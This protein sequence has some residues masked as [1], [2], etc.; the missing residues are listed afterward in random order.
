MRETYRPTRR[1]GSDFGAH[2]SQPASGNRDQQRI[3]RSSPE[4]PKAQQSRDERP[5][6]EQP[7][8]KSFESSDASD[9]SIFGKL[10]PEL[11][12]ALSA[13]GYKT[14]T[15]IQAQCI[16]HLLKGR[17][18]LG[19]AQT[20][21][22]KTAAFTLPLLQYVTQNPARRVRRSPRV[23]ILAPTRELAAQI[24]DSIKTYGAHLPIRQAVIFG[25]VGQRPQEV[26]MSRGVD[27]LVATPGRLIDLMGQGFVSLEAVEAFVLDEADRMLD[28]GFIRDIRRV[29]EKLPSERH[30]LFFSATF[31]SEIVSLAGSMLKDPVRVTIAPEKPTVERIDQKVMFVDRDRKDE[32]LISLLSDSAIDKVIVFTQQKH[33]AN[34]VAERLDRAGIRASAIHG[35]KSQGARTKA[36]EG[37]KVGKVRVLVATDIAAR[38]ID[39][40]GVT[41]VINYHLPMEPETYVH[42]I[43]RTARAGADG[44]AVSFCCASERD[45]L[46]DIERLI[47]KP[48]PTDEEH[49]FHSEVASRATGAEARPAKRGGGGGGGRRQSQGRSS[50]RSSSSSRGNRSNRSE[51]PSG[52]YNSTRS[53]GGGGG[54]SSRGRYRGR[55]SMAR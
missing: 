37:F 12:E 44:D 25:G 23:L 24:S 41:H 54:S 30:S 32:L 6:D 17:D 45:Q 18:L 36:L 26:A 13:S 14:P 35:N 34:K 49:R 42:R 43:G 47:R 15:P 39:V 55:R 5:R 52:N 1:Y 16:P 2:K 9:D 8:A 40:D 22:G 29:I 53:S 19:S 38:G 46:R 7:R 27:F 31:S 48:I 50:N 28:M 11:R 10:I 21:T 20:G 3:E 33:V 51:R 4:R